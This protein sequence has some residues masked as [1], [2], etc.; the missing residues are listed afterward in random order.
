MSVFYFQF[1][2]AF[3]VYDV[4]TA[5]TAEVKINYDINHRNIEY[6]MHD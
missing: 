2:S 5:S 6:Y 3:A 1:R 4:S